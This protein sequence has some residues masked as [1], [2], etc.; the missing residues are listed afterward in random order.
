MIDNTDKVRQIVKEKG[1]V[2]E[3]ERHPDI[4]IIT[5]EDDVKKTGITAEQTMKCICFVRKDKAFAVV[6]RGSER[7]DNKKLRAVSGIKKPRCATPEELRDIFGSELGGASVPAIPE[8]MPI[9]V[10]KKLM[11]MEWVKG[12][13][14]CPRSS[15]ALNPQELLKLPN[16]KVVDITED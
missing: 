7:I 10:D 4:E 16:V 14:G 6:A 3:V 8:H 12:S 13:A 9:Y 5:V 11:G 15:L 2:A 1:L